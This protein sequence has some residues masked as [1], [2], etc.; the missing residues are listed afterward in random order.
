[1]VVDSLERWGLYFSGPIWT[2]AFEFLETLG[3][4]TEEGEVPI[5]G[6]DIFA[7]VASYETKSYE[8]AVFEAH[9]QYVDIQMLL[10]GAED[11]GWFPREPLDVMTPYN[12]ENDVELYGHPDSDP[13]RIGIVPGRFTVFFPDDAHMPQLSVGASSDAV[14]KVVVKIKLELVR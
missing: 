4:E 1:M 7:I 12:E 2:K 3:P 6:E 10:V 11:I 5:Q 14:K 13:V 9:Q 8:D